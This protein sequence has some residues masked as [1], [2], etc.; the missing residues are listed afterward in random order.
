MLTGKIKFFDTRKGFGFIK[1][2]DGSRDVFISVSN[3]PKEG[4]LNPDQKVGYEL[5][6]G[7][8][9]PYAADLVLL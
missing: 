7:K 9:G 8:K 2:D 3:V 1:T 4:Q 6:E 5:R